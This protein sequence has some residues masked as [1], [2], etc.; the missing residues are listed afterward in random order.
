MSVSWWWSNTYSLRLNN[1]SRN[2]SLHIHPYISQWLIISP[3]CLKKNIKLPRKLKK[4]LFIIWYFKLSFTNSEE[5]MMFYQRPALISTVCPIN[6]VLAARRSWRS[7]TSWTRPT[8]SL[9]LRRL[10]KTPFHGSREEDKP[11]EL[12]NK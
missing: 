4:C 12:K 10:S 5:K 8:S 11:D 9:R 3:K 6:D 7:T 1:L 2:G